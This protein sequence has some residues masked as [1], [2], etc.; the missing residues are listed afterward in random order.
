[1]VWFSAE[2]QSELKSHKNYNIMLYD[3]LNYRAPC[4]HAS[5][6]GHVVVTDWDENI[7][8]SPF[9]TIVFRLRFSAD[10]VVTPVFFLPRNFFSGSATKY[11]K[12]IL[13]Y[14]SH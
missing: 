1:M 7:A 13:L 3:R 14:T 9:D 10:S 2:N 12:D 5:C 11:T 8:F 4:V 6:A